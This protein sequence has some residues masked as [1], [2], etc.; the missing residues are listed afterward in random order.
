MTLQTDVRMDGRGLLQY[1]RFFFE[2]RGDKNQSIALK[3]PLI[4]A[5]DNYFYFF[6]FF[7]VR[8]QV[9][10]FHVN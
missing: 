7:S 9:L 5:A 3:V 6:F 8:K 2:K 10:T 4:T 1:P